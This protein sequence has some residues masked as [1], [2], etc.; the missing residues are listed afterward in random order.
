MARIEIKQ[1]AKKLSQMEFHLLQ[2]AKSEITPAT[3]L[4]QLK[5]VLDKELQEW[6]NERIKYR[7]S[8]TRIDHRYPTQLYIISNEGDILLF[9]TRY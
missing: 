9:S 4:V 3:P 8:S 7:N 2:K 6:K 5:K 1:I